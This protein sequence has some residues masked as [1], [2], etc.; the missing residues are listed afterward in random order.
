MHG[1]R[2][3]PWP[4]AI[5]PYAACVKCYKL[6]KRLPTCRYVPR[7]LRGAQCAAGP[8]RAPVIVGCGRPALAVRGLQQVA[9]S[10]G[11]GIRQDHDVFIA[12]V[13]LLPQPHLAFWGAAAAE[14][15]AAGLGGA[16]VSAAA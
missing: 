5:K 8:G 4:C 14:R 3:Q 16:G 7:A 9:Q 10:R 6:C 1:A 15:R 13:C 2:N 11:R 12:L